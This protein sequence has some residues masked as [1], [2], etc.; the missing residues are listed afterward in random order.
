MAIYKD[1]FLFSLFQPFF[2]NKIP[3]FLS[4][5]RSRMVSITISVLFVDF[6]SF[7]IMGSLR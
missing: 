3:N 6:Q 7:S 1:N 4:G 5:T 2:F